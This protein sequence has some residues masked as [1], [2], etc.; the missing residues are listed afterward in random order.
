MD[1]ALWE[2]LSTPPD[3]AGTSLDRYVRSVRLARA[4]SPS[5]KLDHV[6][7]LLATR[8]PNMLDHAI[9]SIIEQLDVEIQL[10]VG[11]HGTWP[12]ATEQRL[13][14]MWA[15]DVVAIRA[16]AT[17]SLGGLLGRMTERA[18]GALVT[19]WDDDDWYGP[20]HVAD[21][22]R[23]HASSGAQLVGKAAEFVWLEAIGETIRRPALGAR[24]YSTN[25][26]GG[27]L[28]MSRS[29]LAEAGGFPDLPRS[30]DR[31]LIDTIRDR[32]G[33]VYRTH[34]LEFVLRRSSSGEHTWNADANYFLDD[35]IDRRPGL[36]LSF[37]D[38]RRAGAP[39]RDGAP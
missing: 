9:E 15:G 28:L 23:A 32:G 38:I 18:D 31:V 2:A 30:V 37:A 19:K 1:T 29:D 24:T 17:T 10:V 34:G 16:D 35:A 12:S 21:L 22:V 20:N 6:S 39:S 14:A 33:T 25:L 4:A 8:R 3:S 5:R 11:L 26:A 36:D 13:A 27:T 7:V